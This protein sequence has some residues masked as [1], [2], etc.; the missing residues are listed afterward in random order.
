MDETAKK[1]QLQG[2]GN[3]FFRSVV[4]LVCFLAADI[5]FLLSLKL[6]FIDKEFATLG[7]SLVLFILFLLP[8]LVLD[9]QIQVSRPV[10]SLCFVSSALV[11]LIGGLLIGLFHHEVA[12]SILIGTGATAFGIAVFGL[13]RLIRFFGSSLTVQSL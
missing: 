2:K 4:S 5:Q 8:Y 7:L 10:L 12:Y 3:D 6:I 9:Q 13:S 1:E 11:G